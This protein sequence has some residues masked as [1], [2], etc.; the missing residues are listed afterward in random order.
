MS[1]AIDK[2]KADITIKMNS[3][4]RNNPAM[5]QMKIKLDESQEFVKYAVVVG[6]GA[7]LNMGLLIML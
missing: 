1:Y 3:Y 4:V 6:S 2:L 5:I 7:L